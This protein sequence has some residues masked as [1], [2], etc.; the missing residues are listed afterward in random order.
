MIEEEELVRLPRVV[1][2]QVGD[3]EDIVGI[4]LGGFE[5]VAEGLGKID[6]LVLIVVRIALVGVI[7]KQFAAVRQVN[8]ARIGVA[9]G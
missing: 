2:I 7:E 4:P 1:I 5:I 3:G 8:Q 9:R 6:P